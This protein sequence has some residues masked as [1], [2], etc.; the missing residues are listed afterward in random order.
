MFRAFHFY[1]S[2]TEIQGTLIRRKAKFY[3]DINPKIFSKKGNQTISYLH[4]I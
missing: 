2:L 4:A 1:A 3:F